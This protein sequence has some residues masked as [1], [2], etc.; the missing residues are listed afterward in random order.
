MTK[1]FDNEEAS[2]IRKSLLT[3]NYNDIGRAY[4]RW[5]NEDHHDDRRVFVN[6]I[7]MLLEALEDMKKVSNN[8]IRVAFNEHYNKIT[9]ELEE[10][11]SR[12]TKEEGGIR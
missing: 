8:T 3:S 11:L 7:N 9:E 4:L 2:E 6:I 1:S 10:I 5:S 12:F